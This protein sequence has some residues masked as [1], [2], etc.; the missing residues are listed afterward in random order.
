MHGCL[1][2]KNDPGVEEQ[3][4]KVLSGRLAERKLRVLKHFNIQHVDCKFEEENNDDSFLSYKEMQ[5]NNVTKYLTPLMPEEIEEHILS[6]EEGKIAHDAI[7]NFHEWMFK[8][9]HPLPPTAMDT[10]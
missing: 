8:S 5:K 6:I 10:L 3:S 9:M 7:I 1:R 4:T 2:L